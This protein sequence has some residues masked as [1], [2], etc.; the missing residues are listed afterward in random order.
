[1]GKSHTAVDDPVL[2]F[3]AFHSSYRRFL[4]SRAL[5][6]SS[7]NSSSCFEQMTI[8]SEWPR[9]CG[10]RGLNS[11][12]MQV[13]THELLHGYKNSFNLRLEFC[14]HV[15][16][17]LNIYSCTQIECFHPENTRYLSL[18]PQ[19]RRGR[20]R[21]AHASAEVLSPSRRCAMWRGKKY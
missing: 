17:R 16:T 1:M 15:P 6:A 12:V 2:G 19:P 9:L 21:L 14:F 3:Q 4:S 5:L 20:R 13:V 8:R 11:G 7:S 18:L 10:V